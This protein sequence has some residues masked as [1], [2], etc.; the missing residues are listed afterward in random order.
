VVG[1]LEVPLVELIGAVEGI[2]GAM[3]EVEGIPEDSVEGIPVDI[4]LDPMW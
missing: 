3:V 1:E 4:I 2:R